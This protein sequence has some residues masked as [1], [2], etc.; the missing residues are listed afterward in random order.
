MGARSWP[1]QGGREPED[2]P[3]RD[4]DHLDAEADIVNSYELQANCYLTKPVH[5]TTSRAW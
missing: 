4:P 1:D 2:Y 3:D 5:W